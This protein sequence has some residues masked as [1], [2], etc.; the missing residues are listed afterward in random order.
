MPSSS[1]RSSPVCATI[2]ITLLNSQETLS[3]HHPLHH[4]CACGHARACCMRAHRVERNLISVRSNRP[5][6]ETVHSD[7][8][9]H[10]GRGRDNTDCATVVCL[11]SKEPPEPGGSSASSSP[12]LM[13]AFEQRRNRR[14]LRPSWWRLRQ[15]RESSITPPLIFVVIVFCRSEG[16]LDIGLFRSPRFHHCIV[17]VLF[18][19]P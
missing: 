13:K 18:E 15:N 11:H 16:G 12:S 3:I 9:V 1:L 5:T 14:R 2:D 7:S 19:L 8:A 6:S 4:L 10:P 17:H